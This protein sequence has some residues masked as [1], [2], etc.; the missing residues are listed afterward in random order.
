MRPENTTPG[1]KVRLKTYDWIIEITGFLFAVALLA[2][3]F[4]YMRELP[5]RIPIHFNGAGTPDGYGPRS[6]IFLLPGIGMVVYL[7][8]TIL[9]G[10]P[11]LYNYPVKIT[12]ENAVI[13]FTLASRFIRILKVLV[14]VLFFYI[15]YQT[16][17][18]ALGL[19]SGLGKAFLP[20]FLLLIAGSTVIYFVLAR[21]NIQTS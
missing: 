19:T 12:P 8:L 6:S 11:N 7:L 15:C 16:I 14:L 4:F 17:N 1:I 18:T 3:P 2:L 20:V 5:E 13:Q 21:N 10:F 9:S